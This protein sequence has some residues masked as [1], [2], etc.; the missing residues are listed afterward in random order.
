M[1]TVPFENKQKPIA[2]WFFYK[3]K[4]ILTLDS[5]YN[6]FYKFG[7]YNVKKLNIKRNRGTCL[8]QDFCLEAINSGLN[9]KRFMSKYYTIAVWIL[10]VFYF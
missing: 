2:N 4:F 9:S 1:Y 6:I 7:P 8:L 10:Y 5:L 3:R